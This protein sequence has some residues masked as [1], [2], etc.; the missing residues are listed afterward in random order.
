M[1]KSM[2]LLAAVAGLAAAP[3]MAGEGKTVV[4]TGAANDA[5]NCKTQTIAQGSR[6]QFEQPA[7]QAASKLVVSGVTASLTDAQGQAI[8]LNPLAADGS[9]A[10]SADITAAGR[11]T[12]TVT[13]GG[14]GSVCLAAAK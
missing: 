13:Q 9:K 8:A 6:Y 14:E 11:Y 4:L 3:A 2:L 7:G 12:L 1:K 5:H 10:T